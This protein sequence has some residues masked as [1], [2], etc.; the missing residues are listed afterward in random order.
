MFRYQDMQSNEMANNLM[1]I[2]PPPA[3][4][5]LETSSLDR[6]W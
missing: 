1:N 5:W 4:T 3:N 6:K 2:T